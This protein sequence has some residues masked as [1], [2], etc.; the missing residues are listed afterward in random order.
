MI[1]FS[2]GGAVHLAGLGQQ[3]VDRLSEALEV[4]APVARLSAVS[5]G[6]VGIAVD[7]SVA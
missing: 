6:E 5:G 7:G 1:N 3:V 4:I 2:D